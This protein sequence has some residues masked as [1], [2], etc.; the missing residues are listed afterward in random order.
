MKKLSPATCQLILQV[1]SPQ[2]QAEVAQILANECAD[3]LPLMEHQDEVWARTGA[4]C[5]PE[6]KSGQHRRAQV[7]GEPGQGQLE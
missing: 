7:V 2:D 3:N 4:L 5:R 1:F 6:T